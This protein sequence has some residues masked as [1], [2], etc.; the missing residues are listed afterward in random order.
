MV[1]LGGTLPDSRGELRGATKRRRRLKER[2]DDRTRVRQ[3]LL[4]IA[5][6]KSDRERVIPMSAELFH[7]VAQIIRRLT[8][9]GQPIALLPRYDDHER[10]WSDSMPYLLQ[11]QSGAD[12]LVLSCGGVLRWL[13]NTCTELS[14]VHPAYK[15]VM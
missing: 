15:T 12:R 9:D 8:S 3:P 10:T 2:I 14:S 6:A 5:P 4:P 11:R 7:V 1:E 13:I